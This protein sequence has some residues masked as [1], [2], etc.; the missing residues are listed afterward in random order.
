MTDDRR[1]SS[2]LT[3]RDKSFLAQ[4]AAGQMSSVQESVRGSRQ[5]A[6]D[7]AVP[8][9]TGSSIQRIEDLRSQVAVSGGASLFA[10]MMGNRDA[11]LLELIR[12]T[13]EEAR[14]PTVGSPM[15]ES[16]GL[17]SGLQS[18]RLLSPGALN[19]LDTLELMASS[20]R[21]RMTTL[22]LMQEF[23]EELAHSF[24]LG[25]R[26]GGQT[27]PG[28]YTAELL[29]YMPSPTISTRTEP[30]KRYNIGPAAS[31]ISARPGLSSQWSPRTH[32]GEH[33][34]TGPEDR[35]VP[36]TTSSSFSSTGSS[37]YAADTT[38]SP[39]TESSETTGTGSLDIMAAIADRILSGED[40]S[41]RDENLTDG[42]S[43]PAATMDHGRNPKEA[44]TKSDQKAA[45]APA[46]YYV[47][48]IRDY[49]VL[50]GRGTC[51]PPEQNDNAL[52][53]YSQDCPCFCHTGGKSNHNPGNKRYR[54]L[55]SKQ[56]PIYKTLASKSAKTRMSHSIVDFICNTGRFLEKEE[57]TG[58]FY[59]VTRSKAIAKTSQALRETKKFK[60]TT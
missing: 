7:A 52:D 30:M 59:I 13:E 44:S 46:H 3:M 33:E 47:N 58:R 28:Q 16:V 12:K 9:Q 11:L 45:D 54:D 8:S 31:T 49:D 60:W 48:D 5:V 35:N 10:G 1:V 36:D 55:V 38:N 56:R 43:Q 37:D 50:L 20:E 39:G 26:M 53:V 41:S 42:C 6:K 18:V 21:N 27:M 32:A 25:G 2:P 29:S 34:S 57:S 40:V 4:V 51:V 17:T 24:L 23:K 22:K 14:A 19:H 15:P